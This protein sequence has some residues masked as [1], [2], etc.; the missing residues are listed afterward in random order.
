M[1]LLEKFLGKKKKDNQLLVFTLIVTF[2]SGVVDTSVHFTRKELYEQLGTLKDV[3]LYTVVCTPLKAQ[4][5]WLRT[6]STQYRV[7]FKDEHLPGITE[8]LSMSKSDFGQKSKE[9]THERE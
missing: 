5:Q 2:S 4:E 7:P 9:V 8:D 6:K 1:S 3:F